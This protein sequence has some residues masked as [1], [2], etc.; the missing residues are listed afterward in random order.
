MFHFNKIDIK[1]LYMCVHTY[2]YVYIYAHTK[3]MEPRV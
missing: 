2:I 1:K 3:A